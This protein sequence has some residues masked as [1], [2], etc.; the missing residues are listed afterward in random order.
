MLI[1]ECVYVCALDIYV[2]VNIHM[3]VYVLY[4]IHIYLLSR[5]WRYNCGQWGNIAALRESL[6]SGAWDQQLR[7]QINKRAVE[8][9][10]MTGTLKKRGP[11][12]VHGYEMLGV[13]S[14]GVDIQRGPL[15][16]GHL[17]RI[18]YG[19]SDPCR[20][21]GESD[22]GWGHSKCKGSKLEISSACSRD[23]KMGWAEWVGR[24]RG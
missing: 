24:W 22:Q 12:R 11:E 3:C 17:S 8:L 6:R 19:M 23:E 10:V 18:L 16:R 14:S 21:L 1:R 13:E 7:G 5:Y 9:Q 2:C 15:L 20:V 4:F